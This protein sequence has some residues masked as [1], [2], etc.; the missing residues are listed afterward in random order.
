MS[1][2]WFL[3]L[4]AAYYLGIVLE[5]GVIGAWLGFAAWIIPLAI[6]M[7]LKVRTGSWKLIEV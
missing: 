4:P 6:V 3:F 1:I 5:M 7:A 2:V